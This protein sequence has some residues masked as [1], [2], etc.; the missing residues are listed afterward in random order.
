MLYVVVIRFV[1]LPDFVIV[2]LLTISADY[3][4]VSW[5]FPCGVSRR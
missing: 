3:C 4:L 1:L 2:G 5:C